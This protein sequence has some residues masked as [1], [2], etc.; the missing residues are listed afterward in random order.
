MK[1]PAV[2][3]STVAVMVGLAGCTGSSTPTPSPTPTPLTEKAT[4]AVGVVLPAEDEPR[5][6]LVA[7]T[8]TYLL[9][10]AGLEVTIEYGDSQSQDAL[11]TGFVDAGVDAMIVTPADP[12]ATSTGLDAAD[13]AG[14][15][16]VALD[17]LPM[18]ATGV[19]FFVAPDIYGFGYNAG[20]AATAALG[21]TDE[22]GNPTGVVVNDPYQI[23]VFGGD[24]DSWDYWFFYN[25]T[26]RDSLAALLESGDLVIGSGEVEGEAVATVAGSSDA[27]QDRMTRLLTDVYSDGQS[28]SAVITASPEIAEGVRAALRGTEHES[29]I[30]VTVGDDPSVIDQLGEGLA[31]TVFYDVRTVTRAAAE[32]AVALING[33]QDELPRNEDYFTETGSIPTRLT[34]PL[35]LTAQN[36]AA[37]I[38]DTWYYTDDQLR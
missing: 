14:I 2:A 31:A 12:M 5:W 8:L 9:S 21:L 24:I 10:G 27:A 11:I 18:T 33:T 37:L 17:E 38:T 29:A 4:G 25:G 34:W 22:Q 23:E 15:P 26:V 35:I 36:R 7:D 32:T 19:D 20:V 30:I 13:A 1:V 3:L 6:S 16:V 28:L